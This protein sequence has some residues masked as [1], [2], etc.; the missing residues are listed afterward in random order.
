M[1]SPPQPEAT[2]ADPPAPVDTGT[3]RPPPPLTEAAPPPV[4]APDRGNASPAPNPPRAPEA[5][6]APDPRVVN[7]LMARGD[8]MMARGDISG[9]RLFYSRAAAAG[10]AAAATAMGR[11]FDPAVLAELGVRGI[12][13]DREQASQ[14]YRRAAELGQSR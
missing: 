13:P 4:L 12:R 2:R 1:E 6:P 8:Q 5:R 3:L 9:A 10:S 11:S 7:M 14:W